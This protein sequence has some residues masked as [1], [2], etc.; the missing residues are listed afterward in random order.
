MSRMVPRPSRALSFGGRRGAV[1]WWQRSVPSPSRALPAARCWPWPGQAPQET[2]RFCRAC[3]KR[4]SAL[5]AVCRRGEAADWPGFLRGV[6]VL[7]H[8][9]LLQRQKWNRVIEIKISQMCVC[10]QGK[11]SAEHIHIPLLFFTSKILGKVSRKIKS[12]MNNRYN[13]VCNP[14]WAY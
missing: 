3:A 12:A 14:L 2:R 6:L 5:P 11:S 4:S 9:C 8:L 13:V 10:A 7:L 1:R